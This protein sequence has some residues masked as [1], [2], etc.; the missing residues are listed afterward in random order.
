M[1]PKIKTKICSGCDGG[2][3]DTKNMLICK[4]GACQKVFCKLCIPI[5]LSLAEKN[6]WT[7]PNCK[8]TSKRGGDNSSTPVR[9]TQYD[10]NVT[11]RKQ[12]KT[13]QQL[14]STTG[15][16]PEVDKS[17]AEPA[18]PQTPSLGTPGDLTELTSEIKL[19]RGDMSNLRNQLSSALDSLAKC[20]TRMDEINGKLADTERRLQALEDQQSQNVRIKATLQDLENKY[21]MQAQLALRNEIE[22]IGCP[23][24]KNEN[25][26]HTTMAIATKIGISVSELDIDFV[27]RVGPIRKQ[28]SNESSQAPRPVI[29]RFARRKD[30]RAGGP[31][32]LQ[33]LLDSK[34]IH[35]Q[36]K[37]RRCRGHQ[38]HQLRLYRPR[39]WISTAA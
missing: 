16:G 37:A 13:S 29:V 15:S 11:M 31:G 12:N 20:Q 36:K 33:I 18:M 9:T 19:L 32:K 7:C 25:L 21:N 24:I 39:L 8:A 14:Q 26:H 10:C 5:E 27:S 4:T 1:S 35:L 28:S 3:S 6:V 2:I 38:D 17:T 22:I 34:W 30:Q 23:E